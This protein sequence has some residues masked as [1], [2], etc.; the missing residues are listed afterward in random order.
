[1]EQRIDW[2]DYGKGIGIILVVYAHLL[3]SP[4]VKEKIL[5]LLEEQHSAILKNIS[6]GKFERA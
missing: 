6:E 4:T 1:M 3:S 2:V 5:Q